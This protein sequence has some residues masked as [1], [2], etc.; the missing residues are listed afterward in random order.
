MAAI[1]IPH[2]HTTNHPHHL[3]HPLGKRLGYKRGLKKIGQTDGVW[4]MRG[5]TA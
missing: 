1:I 3:R 4:G 2:L 5:I